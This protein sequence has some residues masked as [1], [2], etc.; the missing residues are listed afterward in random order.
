[1]AVC[2][3]KVYA[4]GTFQAREYFH[5]GTNNALE[6]W[7]NEGRRENWGPLMISSSYIENK[8]KLKNLVLLFCVDNCRNGKAKYTGN[9]DSPQDW[10]KMEEGTTVSASLQNS[11]KKVRHE[12]VSS[13]Q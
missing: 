2:E 9:V 1:M 11:C 6:N 12:F 10:I 5:T 13:I 4:K 3:A 7:S 8:I